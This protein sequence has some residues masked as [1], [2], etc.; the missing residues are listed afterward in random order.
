[1]ETPPPESV[2]PTPAPIPTI[3]LNSA[4]ATNVANIVFRPVHEHT[5][6]IVQFTCYDSLNACEQIRHWLSTAGP[7][8]IRPLIRLEDQSLD[9][10]PP[11]TRGTLTLLTDAATLDANPSAPITLLALHI[12]H[13]PHTRYFWTLLSPSPLLTHLTTTNLLS[14]P[15]LYS[16]GPLRHSPTDGAL[17]PPR[18]QT[19][20]TLLTTHFTQTTTPPH[21]PAFLAASQLSDACPRI[22]HPRTAHARIEG[23]DALHPPA[24]DD[25]RDL[26][27]DRYLLELEPAERA[28]ASL[29]GAGCAE[30]LLVKRR[31]F[32]AFA[33][34]VVLGAE[35]VRRAA[36]WR[37]NQRLV[38]A[39]TPEEAAVTEG[40]E[41]EEEVKPATRTPMSTRS[42][43]ASSPPAPLSRA[44]TF[45]EA[46]SRAARLGAE[47]RR[48]RVRPQGAHIRAV[49]A[50][51]GWDYGRAR[52]LVLGWEM[53]GFLDEGRVLAVAEGREEGESEDGEE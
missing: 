37:V 46:R 30:Y 22:L 5:F 53:L 32:R 35:K 13:S 26:H 16:P 3:D 42:H 47:M 18:T 45:Y 9:L 49:Q 44:A 29:V 27:D 52:R 40:E 24:L 15:R 17:L 43:A 14:P 25:E 48:L 31:Y 38:G 8:D 50:M 28:L 51:S 23:A 1:M 20:Y 19:L 34:E 7:P 10:I 21:S 12:P 33:R 36:A 6:P 4:S 41:G 2:T 11:Q 39:E